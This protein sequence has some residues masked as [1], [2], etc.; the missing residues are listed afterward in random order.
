MFRSRRSE[1]Y[2]VFLGK[3]AA[4]ILAVLLCSYGNPALAHKGDSLSHKT[5]TTYF[6]SLSNLL[7][8][9]LYG[10]TRFSTLEFV[11]SDNKAPVDYSPNA[12]FNLGLGFSYRWMGLSAAFNFRFINHDDAL[13]GHSE[14]IDLEAEIT[15]RRT[16]WNG[17]FQTF[18][19]YY[20][21]NVDDYI[22]DWN[23][24]DSVPIRPD[25]GSFSFNVNGIYVMN[26]NKFSFRAAYSNS[27][28][29]HKTAGSWLFGGYVSAYGV[30]GD[31]SL[32]P[33][34]LDASYPTFDSLVTLGAFTLGGAAGYTRTWVFRDH[35][36]VNATLFL[37]LSFQASEATGF[38]DQV[39]YQESSVA[40][41]THFRLAVGYN[42]NKSYFGVSV[43]SESFL[44][45]HKKS[46]QLNFNYGLVRLYYGRRFNIT[47]GKHHS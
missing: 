23:T 42:S 35:F 9:Y 15:T 25:I 10:Y 7:S 37:G 17:G 26:H 39:L 44:A 18:Q 43:I 16:L 11:N 2:F 27:E 38:S 3:K 40:P 46:S 14:N 34:S 30:T 29:Q 28:W 47:S 20:W 8:V 41:K 24:E 31:S 22:K 12:N 19:G 33:R 36:F 45:K 5:D 32:I 13:Y 1:N 21:K 6:T 4:I